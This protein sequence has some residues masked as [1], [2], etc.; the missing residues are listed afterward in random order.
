VD[1]AGYGDSRP[2]VPNDNEANR[3]KNRR[4]EFKVVAH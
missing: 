3:A 1:A 4:I 2:I